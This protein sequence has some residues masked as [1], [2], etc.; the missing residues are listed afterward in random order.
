[1]SLV[2]LK[3]I[4]GHAKENNYAVGA[5]NVSSLDVYHAMIEAAVEEGSPIILQIAEVHFD[6]IN[7]DKMHSALVD[8]ADRAEIPICIHLDH[9]ENL[10]V[11]LKAIREGFSSVMFDGSR[12]SLQENIDLTKD[13]VRIAHNIGVSVEGEIGVVGWEA[14]EGDP[15]TNVALKELFTK[16]EEAV[17]F[18]QETGV[19][20][21]AIAI[22]SVHGLYKGKPELDFERL[23][24]I[25]QATD[26]PLVLHG[27]SGIS[28]QDFKKAIGMGICKINFYTEISQAAIMQTRD[29]LEK[30]LEA[31]HYSDLVKNSMLAVKETVKQK[32]RVIGS[33]K[34]FASGKYL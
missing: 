16:V 5:F 24:S 13:I 4:L 29:Y 12:Y 34:R 27:G 10:K 2:N 3:E 32:M 33:S 8:T 14:V 20:A 19:D 28:D 26:M 11:I 15:S 23:D 21:L 25:M 18:K 7:L 1:M 22:G 31:I 6:C 9:G 17:R 30:N